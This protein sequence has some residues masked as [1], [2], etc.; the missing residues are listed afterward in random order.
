MGNAN[1]ESLRLCLELSKS[2]FPKGRLCNLKWKWLQNIRQLLAA[3]CNLHINMHVE[4]PVC[5]ECCKLRCRLWH[6]H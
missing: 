6:M 1:Q 4:K 2:E 3:L 5:T